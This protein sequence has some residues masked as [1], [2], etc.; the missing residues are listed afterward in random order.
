[1][2]IGKDIFCG[3]AQ[4]FR[5]ANS[6]SWHAMSK[7]SSPPERVSELVYSEQLIRVAIFYGAFSMLMDAK[8][9]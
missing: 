8:A 3:G 1:M 7:T 5:P 6:L 2:M 9:G 4:R